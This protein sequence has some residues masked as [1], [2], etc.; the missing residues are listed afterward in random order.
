MSIEAQRKFDE[1][2]A[3]S[4]GERNVEVQHLFDGG[5]EVR[6]WSPAISDEYEFRFT[7]NPDGS[8]IPTHPATNS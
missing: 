5:C 2:L 1:W 4:P 3:A 8:V 7:I 6:F